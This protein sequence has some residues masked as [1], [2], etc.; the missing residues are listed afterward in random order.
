MPVP[1]RALALLAAMGFSAVPSWSAAL[2][3]PPPAR[4]VSLAPSLTEILYGMDLGGRVVGVT[5]FCDRPAEARSKPKVGGVSNPSLEAIAALN[6]DLVVMT[7]DGNPKEVADRLTGLGLKIYVFSAYRLADVPAAIRRMGAALGAVP[8]AERMAAS[9]EEAMRAPRPRSA[10]GETPVR[11]KALFVIWPA[12]LIVAGPG[13]VLDDAMAAS[14][15]ANIASDAKAHYPHFSL[16]AVIERNPDLII[17]GGGHG[18]EEPAKKLLKRL[19][20]LDAVKAGHVCHTGD[21]L[22]RPGPRLPEGLA[23]LRR[24]GE[25]R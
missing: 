4:I 17:I 23:E 7:K 1:L 3:A 14:G 24:C 5:T 10:A 22:Y 12:P 19:D 13:T 9:I 16:E 15:F 25:M 11:R 20:M 21:A 18:M 8:A 6:P 2:G